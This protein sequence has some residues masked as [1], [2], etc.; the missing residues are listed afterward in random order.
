MDLDEK[1]EYLKYVTL[2]GIRN[3]YCAQRQ[4]TVQRVQLK[5]LLCTESEH[6]P[7]GTSEVCTVHRKDAFQ[8]VHQ[9]C[10]LCRETKHFPDGTAEMCTVHRTTLQ[11]VHIK[12]YLHITKRH[13]K[14]L[15]D[16]QSFQYT[17]YAV[18]T[19]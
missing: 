19:K 2:L 3:A 7:D 15:S 11:T 10:V 18:N 14:K 1:V 12:H 9:K 4:N 16:L 5:C 17:K 13:I 8:T 6:C